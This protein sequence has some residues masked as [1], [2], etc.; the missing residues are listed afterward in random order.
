MTE[1]VADPRNV[2][3]PDDGDFAGQAMPRELRSIKGEILRLIGELIDAATASEVQMDAE[4]QAFLEAMELRIDNAA[5]LISSKITSH[6]ASKNNPHKVTAE[7]VGLEKVKNYGYFHS[8]SAVL[9]EDKYVTSNILRDIGTEIYSYQTVIEEEAY[10][11][12]DYT[13]NTPTVKRGFFDI[14]PAK[15][16]KGAYERAKE[17]G[18]LLPN[19]QRVYDGIT[20]YPMS[21]HYVK[22]QF[23]WIEVKLFGKGSLNYTTVHRGVLP[24]IQYRKP[25]SLALMNYSA[26]NEATFPFVS[27]SSV[28]FGRF[29]GGGWA[30]Y[31]LANSSYYTGYGSANGKTGSVSFPYGW[32]S[33]GGMWG[34]IYLYQRGDYPADMHPRDPLVNIGVRFKRNVIGALD[35]GGYKISD[36]SKSIQLPVINWDNI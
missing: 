16:I 28:A 1:Y 8:R 14:Y 32:G 27:T 3:K 2:N 15:G 26:F 24:N 35:D 17:V 22:Y 4:I 5:A 34:E 23:P 30:L 31:S 9:A 29:S 21:D 6:V 10:W 13:F 11:N 25:E 20:K 12:H 18:D 33:N 19:F 7:Q 36:P